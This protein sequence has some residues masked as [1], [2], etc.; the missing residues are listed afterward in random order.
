MNNQFG[1]LFIQLP[2]NLRRIVRFVL[3]SQI[4]TW[5]GITALPSSAHAT[6]ST[7]TTKKILKSKKSKPKKSSQKNKSPKTLTKTSKSRLK[8]Q[9]TRSKSIGKTTNKAVKKITKKTSKP[10]LQ[11]KSSNK[12][13]D[14]RN[15]ALANRLPAKA[16]ASKN[17]KASNKYT[18]PSASLPT[19]VVSA[20]QRSTPAWIKTA[21]LWARWIYA[22]DSKTN[23]PIGKTLALAL[24]G[25]R[26]V[27][28]LDF[29]STAWLTQSDVVFNVE[30]PVTLS[31]AASANN[32]PH[33]MTNTTI[34]LID[35]DLTGNIA[36]FQSHL[37]ISPF[38]SR[39]QFR[40]DPPKAGESLASVAST[41]Y[42]LPGTRFVEAKSNGINSSYRLSLNK[43]GL[44][45]ASY[46][47]DRSGRL[48]SISSAAA[49]NDNQPTVWSTPP[50]SLAFLLDR[51][52]NPKSN[53]NYGTV[54]ERRR[55]LYSWQERWTQNLISPKESFNLAE[56]DCKQN[57]S[58]IR[59]REIASRTIKM[60]ATTCQTPY[61]IYLGSNYQAGANITLGSIQ[62]NSV[63]SDEDLTKQLVYSVAENMFMDL[64]QKSTMV[65]LMTL[66]ECQ[67]SRVKNVRGI[68]LAVRFC[69]SALKN[70]SGLNDTVIAVVD[71]GQGKTNSF[72]V[73]RLKG[74]NQTNT[75]RFIASL[76]EDFGSKK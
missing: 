2:T 65:N 47:F 41:E 53:M 38:V 72:S 23:Q 55:Q 6:T 74:F 58:P 16:T 8:T 61:P 63:V 45:N 20:P 22:T 28:P 37:E 46:Q 4:V 69:T 62:L 33:Q 71:A 75:K 44:T 66:S 50:R 7:T 32:A 21:P 30:A 52:T 5:L 56:L 9:S 76:I 35:L 60:S 25:N 14:P 54:A 13:V 31:S 67:N 1:E 15:R 29:I 40:L 73:A 59:N 42:L 39:S 10:T 48:V 19:P 49:I 26:L 3:I 64:E 24:E 51:Q 70:E 43:K 18:L 34:E 27:A 36:L 11:V 17:S 57:L 12:T 68:Q